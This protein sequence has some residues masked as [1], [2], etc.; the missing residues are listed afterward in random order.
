MHSNVT[1]M[2]PANLGWFWKCNVS[3]H[4]KEL[5]YLWFAGG[6][7]LNGAISFFFVCDMM[8]SSWNRLCDLFFVIFLHHDIPDSHHKTWGASFPHSANIRVFIECVIRLILCPALF[9]GQIL[10][11]FIWWLILQSVLHFHF[12][13]SILFFCFS[14]GLL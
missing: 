7:H 2:F 9:W 12:S 11:R 8:H 1:F 4:S 3:I 5:L 10:S 13:C 14:S 6:S